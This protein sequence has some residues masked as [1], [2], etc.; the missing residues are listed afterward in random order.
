MK[1]YKEILAILRTG[2]NLAKSFQQHAVDRL[3]IVK[4]AENPELA[5]AA[6][7][8]FRQVDKE[9]TVAEFAQRWKDFLRAHP[10]LSQHKQNER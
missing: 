2:K 3:T 6:P 1:R 7:E 8:E 5:I 4:T 9:G 10:T